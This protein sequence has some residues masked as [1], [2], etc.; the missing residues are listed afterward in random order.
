[1]SSRI[2]KATAMMLELLFSRYGLVVDGKNKPSMDF[3]G[4][5][6]SKKLAPHIPRAAHPGT[7]LP[8]H[9]MKTTR[10]MHFLTLFEVPVV[11]GYAIY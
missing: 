3:S 6:L 5:L 9:T 1:M 11:M 10:Y 7:C 8:C 4:F 2:S